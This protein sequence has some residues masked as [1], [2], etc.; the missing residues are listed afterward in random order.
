MAPAI[1]PKTLA[2]LV[3]AV[4]D[5]HCSRRE[6]QFAGAQPERHDDSPP[7]HAGMWRW[8]CHFPALP[9]AWGLTRPPR[10]P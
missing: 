3:T 2:L 8:S 5:A 9:S 6:M 1:D 4:V 7:S 10:R